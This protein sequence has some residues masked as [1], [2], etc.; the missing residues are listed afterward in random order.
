[1]KLSQETIKILENFS[2]INDGI[3]I[4]KDHV[5]GDK[6]EIRSKHHTSALQ[7]FAEI[8]ETF[9]NDVCLSKLKQLLNIVKNIENA[10][11]DFKED[12]VV[13]SGGNF[14]TKLTYTLPNHIMTDDESWYAR[15]PR[16]KSDTI[17]F[18]ISNKEFE[19]LLK[20]ADT[21]QLPEL[22]LDVVGDYV[23]LHAV[24]LLNPDSETAEVRLQKLSKDEK[25]IAQSIFPM[26]F[27]RSLFNLIDGDYKIIAG[28]G[29]IDMY[30][31]TTPVRYFIVSLEV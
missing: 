22:K 8:E 16:L 20:F 30:N 14:K 12:H 26:F 3:I 19:K 27:T 6:T 13:V 15:T 23:T 21:L 9:K 28:N 18:T 7:S 31:Q 10:D 17:E 24:N 4:L 25:T 5:V 29:A 11:V 2:Q 1:M